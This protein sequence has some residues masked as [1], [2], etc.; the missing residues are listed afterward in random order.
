MKRIIKE[1][2][3]LII[4]ITLPVLLMTGFMLASS[5]PQTLTDPPQYDLVFS[6]V[7]YS[8]ANANNIPLSV[9]LVVKEGVLIAQYT[10]NKNTNNYN[11]WKKLYIY[12]SSTRTTRELPFGY[13]ADMSKIT[14][15]REEPVEPLMGKKLSTTLVSPDGYELSFDGYSHSGLLNGIFGGGHSSEPRLRKGASSI[16]LISGDSRISFYYGNVEF[17]GWVVP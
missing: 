15:M 10:R 14:D 2:F 11:Y 8:S 1:N 4:G 3:V 12:E 17:V 5:I 7:D 13:P 6:T 16:R 9:R